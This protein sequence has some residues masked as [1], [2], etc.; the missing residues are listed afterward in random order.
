M[1][2]RGNVK[3][4]ATVSMLLLMVAISVCYVA[5][6][7]VR[8]ADEAKAITIKAVNEA[9]WRL[10]QTVIYENTGKAEMQ[11]NEIASGIE[12]DVKVKYLRKYSKLRKEL[13]NPVGGGD[14][15]VI[16]SNSVKGKFL[17]G[18]KNDNNDPF[19]ANLSGILADK[20]YNCSV[21][22]ESRSWT[23]EINM[24][25]NIPL[26]QKT[27]TR[28]INHDAGMKLWE[29]LPPQNDSHKAITSGNMEELYDVFMAEGIEGLSGY[30][31]LSVAYISPDSDIFGVPDITTPGIRVNNHKIIVVQGFNVVD[32]LKANYSEKLGYLEYAERQ[33]EYFATQRK[34]ERFAFMA[35]QLIVLATA[36]IAI[37]VVIDESLGGG[38]SAR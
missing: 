21:N 30:E 18:I 16:F 20:S 4:L 22:K 14:V 24:H 19:I 36:F 28:I 27:V 34:Q 32:I 9:R 38:K 35:L 31:F 2:C 26:A 6:S 15:Y 25:W 11:A 33:A 29:F 1:K 13:D 10:V 8:N 12:R 23:E 7:E 5:Y 37:A 3:T 17:N